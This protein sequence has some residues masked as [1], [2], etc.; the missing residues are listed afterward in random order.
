VGDLRRRQDG[1]SSLACG[2]EDGLIDA[3]LKTITFLRTKGMP[4][5]QVEI[6]GLHVSFVWHD[7]LIH[8]APLHFQN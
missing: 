4:V 5:T 8:F 1:C 7:N 6:P 3:N 2:T